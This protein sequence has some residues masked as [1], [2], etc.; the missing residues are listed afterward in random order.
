MT[1]ARRLLVLA[2]A[3]ALAACAGA[4]KK[5]QPPADLQQSW[6]D[7]PAGAT[8]AALPPKAWWQDF[9]DPVLDRL[10]SVAEARNLDLRLAEG[11]L[12][13][14]RALARAA[15]AELF[16][17][18]T[19]SVGADRSRTRTRSQ[20]GARTPSTENTFDLSVGATWEAD[21]F[22]RLASEARAAGADVTASEADR[23][24]VRLT[25][26]ADVADAYIE[27]RLYQALADLASKNADAQGGTVRITRARYEQGMSSRLDVERTEAQLATTRATLPQAREQAETARYRLALLLA[28]SPDELTETLPA[29]GPLPQADA[30]AV[31][32]GP[33]Q[34][35][36]QR[37]DVRAAESRLVAAAG[38]VTA[39]QALR[40]PQISLSAMLGV[41]SNHVS[42]LFSPGT[43]VWSVGAGLL[44]PLFDF[45]RISAAI[46]AA[47]AR[48]QQ[49]LAGYE[50]AV[51]TAL[52]EAQTAIV[53]Y[54]QGAIRQQELTRAATA[55]R[56]AADLA[57]RQ[58][59]EGTLSLL[60]VLD[61]ERT[62]YDAETESAQATAD[63]S[64]RLVAVYRT[65]GVVPPHG[66]APD[67]Q[68]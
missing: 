18:P 52:Q 33:V 15:R 56:R 12:L 34:V 60:E 37:P 22:G 66:A 49:A 21:L 23:D 45:G 59:R 68:E 50:L 10:I 24:A 48:Q 57:H 27:L 54:T 38:R 43:R 46:D 30:L 11:R 55:A 4:P 26:L 39:A 44:A 61:A 58:Y 64:L 53:L 20:G 6:Q 31:L 51:R 19:G 35:V 16:P 9:H 17:E 67:R 7:A 36:A 41:E 32:A 40:Y 28:V 25:L 47:D 14:A 3:I 13:E 29:T 63:V 8:T 65:M 5:P 42:E 1:P 2:A 62:L